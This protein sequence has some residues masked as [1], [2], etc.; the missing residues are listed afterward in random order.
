MQHQKYSQ[1][2]ILIVDD[3]TSDVQLITRL[4]SN[5]GYTQLGIEIDSSQAASTFEKFQ[6]DL[7]ILDLHMSPKD[8]FEVLRELNVAIP[9]GSYL[10]VLVIT[11]D[12]NDEARDRALSGGAMDFL[13]KPS[14]SSEI[15]LRVQNLLH[16]RTLHLELAKERDSLE[17]RVE[18]RTALVVKGQSEI[19]ERLA[20]L[21]EFRDDTTGKHTQRVAEIVR[22]I[23][24]AIGFSSE[25][26]ELMGR[27]SLLHD[28]GKVAIPDDILLKRGKLTEE[29]FEQMKTHAHIGGEILAGSTSKL[30]STAESIAR[31]HHE[32]WDGSGYCKVESRL[33]PLEARITAIADVFDAL[34]SSRPYKEAWTAVEALTEMKR[35]SGSHFDPELVV[36]F[37]SVTPSIL[38]MYPRLTEDP[39]DRDLHLQRV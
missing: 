32:K 22:Q 12:I 21:A 3:E 25:A 35:L 9:E 34:M 17:K 6:P 37:L 28:I 8:G 1:A 20:R 16:T 39:Q 36:S 24:V 13:S 26:S 7:V 2:R 4:L 31:Y 11:G 29:E 14:S 18:E 38:S 30:L 15:L 27:A 10:P 23:A 33:I 5:A 19:L